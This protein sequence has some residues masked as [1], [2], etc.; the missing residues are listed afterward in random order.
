MPNLNGPNLCGLLFFFYILI[1]PRPLDQ[2]YCKLLVV[3]A[4]KEGQLSMK[5]KT[6]P[7]H[8]LIKIYPTRI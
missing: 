7:H 4:E 1:R 2:I 6:N 3:G 5:H 8:I